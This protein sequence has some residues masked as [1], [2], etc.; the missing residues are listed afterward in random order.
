MASGKPQHIKLVNEAL[1]RGAL[2]SRGEATTADLVA[3][4]GL[5]QT[6]VGQSIEQMRASGLILEAHKRASSGGRRASAW[7]LNPQAW[8]SIA[9]SI[10]RDGLSWGIAN[11]LGTMTDQGTRLIKNDAL[12]DAV[13]LSSEL[14]SAALGDRGEG[15]CALAVGVP[16]AITGGRVITGDYREAW[17]GV[18]LAS[19]FAQATGLP[20]VLE[21]DLNAIAIGYMRQSRAGGYD[22]RSLVYMHFNEGA[23]IGSGL[24][25]DGRIF[26]GATNFSGEIGFLPM[27]GGKVLNDAVL[28]ARDDGEY[29]EAIVTSLR[30]VT[31]I[32][33]PALIVLGESG[34]RFDLADDI[35]RS[36]CALVEEAVRPSL[37]FVQ[38]S[39]PYYMAGLASLAAELVLPS[40]RLIDDSSIA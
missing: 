2:A 10:E 15:R 20:V 8:S 38:D 34:F 21:N 3:D 5:S 32:V 33:N 19:R 25:L 18:D 37:V 6:T 36:F 16:G 27:G 12:G 31:C 4:T 40:L 29:V 28:G 9:L 26:R 24:V 14:V 23:C 22:P 7:M 1:I 13:K 30:A 17:S 35:R 11:A 39:R